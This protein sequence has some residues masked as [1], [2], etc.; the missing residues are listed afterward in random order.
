GRLRNDQLGRNLSRGRKRIP[1]LKYF[2]QITIPAFLYSFKATAQGEIK[3]H[4][5]SMT[6]TIGKKPRL[7]K[8]TG[9]QNGLELIGKVID[10]S[11]N[12]IAYASITMVGSVH[13]IMTDSM[14]VFTIRTKTLNELVAIEVSKIGYQ[15]RQVYMQT[16]GSTAA[17]ML[18]EQ[19]MKPARSGVGVETL[20]VGRVGG[21]MVMPVKIKKTESR[22]MNTTLTY[23]TL[24]PNPV[25]SGSSLNIELLQKITEGYYLLRLVNTS[26][27]EL[28]RKEIWI[29]ADARVMNIELPPVSV[30]NY[31][32]SLKEKNTGKD[33]VEKLLV[34]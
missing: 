16:Q 23:F 26:G 18:N 1:W 5:I 15:P 3:R 14:G 2:F 34:K 24:F 30:G 21:I 11:G 29:D 20:L 17:I 8:A 13:S 7:A 4:E 10:S 33:F 25:S 31:F 27:S 6:D 9:L 32:L 19:V 28:F 22:K 12:G